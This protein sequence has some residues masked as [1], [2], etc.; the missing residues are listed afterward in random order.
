MRRQ[1]KKKD[2][3]QIDLL[4]KKEE[5]E[6][7]EKRGP[8]TGKKRNRKLNRKTEEKGKRDTQ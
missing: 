4:N 7:M 8:G 1:Q 5:Y 3:D 2:D 6:H